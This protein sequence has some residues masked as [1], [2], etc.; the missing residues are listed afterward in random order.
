MNLTVS[1]RPYVILL[2]LWSGV[3]CL[4][5]SAAFSRLLSEPMP[6]ILRPSFWQSDCRRTFWTISFGISWTYAFLSTLSAGQPRRYCSSRPACRNRAL[7]W[8]NLT[9]PEYGYKE[10]HTLPHCSLNA[11]PGRNDEQQE[12]SRYGGRA[13]AGSFASRERLVAVPAALNPTTGACIERQWQGIRRPRTTT[14]IWIGAAAH[15]SRRN[16][17]IAD[18]DPDQEAAAGHRARRLLRVP[19][20]AFIVSVSGSARCAAGSVLAAG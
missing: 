3:I 10:F 9:A 20:R 16:G 4:L 6:A 1:M 18:W 2:L 5:V 19:V 13:G 15:M 12:Y 8:A 7:G 11:L 14:G 17:M